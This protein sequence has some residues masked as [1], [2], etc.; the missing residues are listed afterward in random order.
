MVISEVGWELRQR[1]FF[2]LCIWPSRAVGPLETLGL[3]G[4]VDVVDMSG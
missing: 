1:G 3:E 2:R 4:V